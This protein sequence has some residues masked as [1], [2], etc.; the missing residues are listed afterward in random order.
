MFL[1]T[2][3]KDPDKCRTF[4]IWTAIL[5]APLGGLWWPLEIVGPTMRKIAYVV[6]TGWAMDSVNSMLAFGAGARD[7]APFAGALAALFAVSLTLA[8]RRL[9]PQ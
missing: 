3:F 7:V 6:P 1:G 2:L 8:A 4:A 9:K 5:L